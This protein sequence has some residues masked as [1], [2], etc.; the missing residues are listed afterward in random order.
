MSF[1]YNFFLN[2]KLFQKKFSS[3]KNYYSFS[4]VDTIIENIFRTEQKGFYVDV[5]CQHPI[6]NNNTYLLYKKGWY[7]LNIDL[8]KDNID[9]F[10]VSRPNDD[11]INIAISNKI[12][13]TD[14]YFYHKKSPINTIDKLTSE[15][16]KAKV[17]EIKKIQTNT[18]NNIL[19]N[20]KYK[21]NKINLLSVDVEGHELQVFEGLDFS[22]YKPEVIVVEFLD[23]DVNKLEI[24]NLNIEKLFKTELYKFL[25]SKDYI[26]VNCIY[27]DLIFINKDFRD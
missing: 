14:L 24:K 8:D 19:S 15:F 18:L 4:G 26:L 9:L 16:Q 3:K 5:G 27:S 22:F 12:G 6:R 1:F 10:N 25:I 23:L 2:L 11:N 7:G 21:N 20:S 17:S 13:K